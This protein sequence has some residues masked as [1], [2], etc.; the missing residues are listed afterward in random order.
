MVGSGRGKRIFDKKIED[1]WTSDLAE[2]SRIQGLA[3]QLKLSYNQHEAGR[4][5]KTEP[6][7]TD[8]T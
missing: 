1:A 7:R 8:K 3:I 6:G 5:G 4:R 2:V